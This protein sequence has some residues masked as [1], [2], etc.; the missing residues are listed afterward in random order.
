MST[1]YTNGED[2]KII[3]DTL[4]EDAKKA[5]IEI[6]E[7]SNFY[8]INEPADIPAND[9]F[10]WYSERYVFNA[11]SNTFDVDFKPYYLEIV[12]DKSKL[13]SHPAIASNLKKLTDSFSNDEKM[14]DWFINRCSYIRNSEMAG[15]MVEKLGM[16]VD[17]FETIAKDCAL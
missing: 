16:S 14:R 2:V 4:T 11:S 15:Y 5:Y 12:L 8:Q 17:T 6:L 1:R 13:L 9:D 10:V 3:D 7:Q